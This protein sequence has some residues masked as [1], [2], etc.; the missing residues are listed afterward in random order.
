MVGN[1]YKGKVVKIHPAMEVAFVKINDEKNAFLYIGENIEDNSPLDGLADKRKSRITLR[2]GDVVLCQ[3][4][5]DEFGTKGARISL[6]VTLPGKFLVM[7]PQTD[8]IGISSKITEESNRERLLKLVDEC[9]PG[10][11]GYI[12]RTAAV[13]AEKEELKEEAEE[14]SIKWKSIMDYYSKAPICSLVY[15][16]EDLFCRSIRDMLSNDVETVIF[17]DAELFGQVIEGRYSYCEPDRAELYSGNQDM[18]SFYGLTP[19]I[20]RLSKKKVVLKNGSSIIIDRTEALTVIDVNTGKY[21]GDKNDNLENT[22]FNTNMLAA[23]EIARQLRLRNI[24]GI[25]IVDFIDM[26]LIEHRNKVLQ[27]F[28]EELKK[29]RIKTTL[30]GMTNLGLVELTRKKMRSSIGGFMLQHCPYC[31]G[32][33]Y[34]KSDEYVITKIREHLLEVFDELD[35]PGAVIRVNTSVF[36]KIF[37]LRYFENEC[38]GVWKGKRIFFIKDETLHIE[39]FVISADRDALNELPEDAAEVK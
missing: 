3:V 19:Q 12:I 7:M 36:N 31:N 2:E 8:Y 22:V 24:G 14:L 30:V 11:Y 38:R 39:K 6:D 15:Q 10:E 17:N 32:D 4:I 20:E 18:L 25:I 37:Q 28:N 33:G 23:E 35:P 16:E 29:D 34:V 27:R 9:R 5:K 21:V 1:I 13:N 26:E